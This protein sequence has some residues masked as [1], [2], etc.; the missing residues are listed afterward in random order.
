MRLF[1]TGATGLLGKRLCAD[2]VSAGHEVWALSRSPAPSGAAQPLNWLQGDPCLEESWTLSVDGCD[3][4]IH[5]AGESVAGR[6]W[7]G[8]QK[9]RLVRSRVESTR[10]IVAAVRK[11]KSPPKL[12]VC[13]SATGFYGSRG[14]EELVEDTEPGEG[15]LAQLCVAWEAAAR[16]AEKEGLRVVSLRFGVVLS[17]QGGALAK[18]LPPFRIALGGPIGPRQHWFPWIHEDDAR[19]LVHHVLEH[20]LAGPVNAVAPGAVRMGEFAQTL[21]RVLRRPARFPVPLALLRLGVGEFAE[22][23]SPG[24]KVIPRAALDSDYAFRYPQL[25]EAL[26]ACLGED[27]GAA[28]AT[29]ANSAGNASRDSR[30]AGRVEAP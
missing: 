11:A 5:L 24:Q 28:V 3:A 25:E 12:L 17:A 4:V 22:H 1:V 23:L 19:G 16:A 30:E 10:Q 15:F 21:G 9:E 8:A 29:S 6:R 2:L 18:M 7:W 13:A 20:P 14:Q 27:A 26:R